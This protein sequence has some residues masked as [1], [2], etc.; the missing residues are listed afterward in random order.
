MTFRLIALSALFLSACAVQQESPES[1]AQPADFPEA[2]YLQAAADTQNRVYRADRKLSQILIRAYRGGILTLLGHEHIVAS[3]DV[4]GYI[5]LNKTTGLCQTDLFVPLAKLNVD[6]PQL[7]TEAELQTTPS[8]SSSD[9]T[10]KNMLENIDATSSPFAQ[11]HS[12]DCSAALSGKETKVLLTIH[13]VKQERQLAIN[14]QQTDDNQLIVSGKLSILQ[15]EFGIEPFS[16]FNGLIQ[17]EDKLDLTYKLVF[18][19][20]N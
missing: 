4:H 14:L 17:V 7:R 9:N 6:D 16:V 19:E 20:L 18:T 13:G 11:L 5:L 15:T 12:S 3:Q 10:K 1:P 2:L 8:L